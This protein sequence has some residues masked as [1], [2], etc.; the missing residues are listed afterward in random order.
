[1]E[2]VKDELSRNSR[3]VINAHAAG[4]KVT[5]EGE[6]ISSTG[7]QRVCKEAGRG[8]HLY[9]EISFRVDGKHAR[10]RVHRLQAFQKFGMK[11]F[12]KGMVVRH[13]NG[14]PLDNSFDNIAIGTASENMM[15]RPQA[16]RQAH[17]EHAASFNTKHAHES[18]YAYYCGVRSYKKT[19]EKFNISSKGTL[20]HII[21][22]F[23]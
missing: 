12:E 11:M 13:L 2:T 14:N 18:V 8:N 16:V 23:K 17:A 22:K 4:Y 10:L 5:K 9:K 19:M 3:A 21:K 1:M 15:D 6:L 7:V 20:N